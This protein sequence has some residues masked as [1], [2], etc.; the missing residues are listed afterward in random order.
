MSLELTLACGE[1]DR[2]LALQDGSVAPEAITLRYVPARPGELFRRQVQD[3]EYDA[4]EM[5]LSTSAHCRCSS[6][7][8]GTL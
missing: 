5:S 2:T 3:T 4:S 7:S 1:Y 6:D 8:F